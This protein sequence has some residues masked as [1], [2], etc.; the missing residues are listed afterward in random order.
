MAKK[1]KTHTIGVDVKAPKSTCEDIKCPFHGKVRVRGRTIFGTVIAQDV[2]KSA[3][4]EIPRS[5]F[6]K[7]YDRYEKKKARMR[8]HNP[9]CLNAKVGEKVRTMEC[10]PLSKS[11]KFVIIEVVGEDIH[12]KQKKEGIEESKKRKEEGSKKTEEDKE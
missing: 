11:K 10:K 4:I 5:K 9:P 7:K 6:I 3:T 8:V 1:T 12:F 2:H